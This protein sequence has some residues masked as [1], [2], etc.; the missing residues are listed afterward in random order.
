MNDE[1]NSRM[2]STDRE[3]ELKRG[4]DHETMELMT[5]SALQSQPLNPGNGSGSRIREEL[6]SLHDVRCPSERRRPCPYRISYVHGFS[7]RAGERSPNIEV[8][9]YRESVCANVVERC[10]SKE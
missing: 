5:S 1:R 4:V 6:P 10:K 8:K 7:R 9:V 2:E 3:I